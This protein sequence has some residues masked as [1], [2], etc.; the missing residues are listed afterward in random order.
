MLANFWHGDFP[1]RPAPGYGI[2]AQ[3][4]AE[5]YDLI[6]DPLEEHNLSHPS[7][8]NDARSEV[9]G[10]A[11]RAGGVAGVNAVA[12]AIGR[13]DRIPHLAGFFLWS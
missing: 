7:Y 13:S 5:P 6:H 4:A 12:I 10:R 2:A 11:V 3:R 9:A 8:A 1:W